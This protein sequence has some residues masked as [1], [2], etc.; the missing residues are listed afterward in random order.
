METFSGQRREVLISARRIMRRLLNYA[1]DRKDQAEQ[2]CAQAF[3]ESKG[4]ENETTKSCEAERKKY[5]K[6]YDTLITTCQGLTAEI[7]E[8]RECDINTLE[9]QNK[10]DK[11]QGL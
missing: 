8:T 11:S 9:L 2:D 6:E 1:T 5:F 10:T 4:Q 7:I 3:K